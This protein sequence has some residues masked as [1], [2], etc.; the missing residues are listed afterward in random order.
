MRRAGAWQVACVAAAVLCAGNFARGQ[1]IDDDVMV[2]GKVKRPPVLT[3]DPFEGEIS[4]T[5]AYENSNSD[6]QKSSSA[7]FE[8]RLKLGTGGG[9]ISKNAIAWKGSITLGLREEWNSTTGSETQSSWG[10][11]HEY[12]LDLSLFPNSMLPS[13]YWARRGENYINRSFAALLRQEQTSYGA[14]VSWPNMTLPMYLRVYHVETVQQELNGTNPFTLSQDTVEY[15]TETMIGDRQKLSLDYQLTTGETNGAGEAEELGSQHLMVNHTLNI[16]PEGRYTLT[17]RLDYS[18]ETGFINYDRLRID[19]QLTLRHTDRFETYYNY[20]ADYQSYPTSETLTNSLTGGFTHRLYESLTTSGRVGYSTTERSSG[21]ASDLA[22]AYLNFAYA[23]KVP[24]GRL[25]AFLELGYATGTTGETGT[26]QEVIGDTETFNDPLPIVLTERG[27]NG[28]TVEVFN[29]TGTKKYVENIDY[30]VRQFSDRVE[31]ERILG[32]DISPNETVRLNY[33]IDPLPGYTQTT[34]TFGFG[35]RYTFKEGPL[36]NLAL[37]ASYR[38]QDQS[39]STTDPDRLQPDDSQT[40]LAGAEYEFWKLT[41]TTEAENR[42]STLSPYKALRFSARYVDRLGPRSRLSINAT[43]LFLQYPDEDAEAQYTQLS[44]RFDYDF[45]REVRM[46]VWAATRL[47]EDSRF[48]DTL[49]FE[50]QA[51]I[52]WRHRQTEITGAVRHTYV[53]SSSSGDSTSFLF[54]LTITRRF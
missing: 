10:V 2:Y 32:G 13:S 18:Q 8:Q 6:T 17:S 36:E 28:S 7:Q 53:T 37:Y 14:Q 9:V 51:E 24:L 49:A 22:T 44:G 5:N 25:G 30:R 26:A 52:R 12:D 35:A 3:L 40:T 48:G 20:S 33:D 34:S 16:D 23:K 42:D 41:L 39:I 38:Q 50:E 15:H 21:G 31:I 43:Q 27:V 1:T 19:E 45:T 29:A 47:N 11:L 46:S 54:L 4:L